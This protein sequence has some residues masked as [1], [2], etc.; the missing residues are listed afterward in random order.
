MS[1]DIESGILADLDEATVHQLLKRPAGCVLAYPH[2]LCGLTAGQ[3]NSPIIKAIISPAD[4]MPDT[5]GDRR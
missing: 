5:P 4:F 1:F 3:G 2:T